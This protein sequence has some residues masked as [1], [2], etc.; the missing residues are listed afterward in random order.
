MIIPIFG[1]RVARPLCLHTTLPTVSPVSHCLRVT[2]K[3]I[4]VDFVFAV[5]IAFS[6]LS[7]GRGRLVRWRDSM[8]LV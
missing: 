6:G 5:F 7:R 2:R 8:S 4:L 3:A 1:P